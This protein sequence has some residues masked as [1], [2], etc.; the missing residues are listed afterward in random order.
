MYK[1]CTVLKIYKN[2]LERGFK[3]ICCV[4]YSSRPVALNILERVFKEIFCVTYSSKPVA[5]AVLLLEYFYLRT[6]VNLCCTSHK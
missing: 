4:T 3:E 2:V 5:L 1:T 6:H